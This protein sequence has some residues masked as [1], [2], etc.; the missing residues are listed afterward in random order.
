MDRNGEFQI[1]VGLS[2]IHSV[3]E[4]KFKLNQSIFAHSSKLGKFETAYFSQGHYDWSLAL[5]PN[6]RADS[7]IGVPEGQ[8]GSSVTVYLTRHSGLDRTCRVKFILKLG[9]GDAQIDSGMLDEASD[10]DGR[11]YGWL[12]RAKLADLVHK[13][14]LRLVVEMVSV[15]VVSLVELP[16]V[17]PNPIGCPLYDNDKHTWELESDLNGDTLRLRLVHKDAKNI[18]RNHIRYVCWAVYLLKTHPK[19]KSA[20]GEGDNAPREYTAKIPMDQKFYF[21]YYVQDDTEVGTLMDTKIP[22]KEIVEPNSGYL[23]NRTGIRI[24]VEWLHS[25]LLFQATYHHYDDVT[26]VQTHQ[27]RQEIQNLKLENEMLDQRIMTYEADGMFS[28][29]PS[30]VGGGG[31][32]GEGSVGLISSSDGSQRRSHLPLAGNN[33]PP[34][35]SAGGAAYNHSSNPSGNSGTLRDED[36]DFMPN[37]FSKF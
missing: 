30:A 13:G 1:E 17:P 21:Q 20:L 15:N 24:H 8:T 28:V 34:G 11:S 35:G 16:V 7:Q 5:Y 25:C 10:S 12:P 27:M 9:D 29:C 32:V 19:L 22:L 3:F 26:R 2:S 33:G 6:G 37:V 31:V 4:H 18:P 23:K 36:K 14:T